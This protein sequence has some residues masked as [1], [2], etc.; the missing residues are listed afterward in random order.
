MCPS[1]D[2][3]K[4]YDFR[5]GQ[6]VVDINKYSLQAVCRSREIVMDVLQKKL[7]MDNEDMVL[8]DA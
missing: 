5:V 2:Q 1:W 8:P 4:P 7:A 3:T 6:M